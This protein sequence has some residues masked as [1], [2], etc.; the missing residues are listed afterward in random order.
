MQMLNEVAG[1]CLFSNILLDLPHARN[2][3]QSSPGYRPTH[4]ISIERTSLLAQILGTTTI[5]VNS[6][7]RQAVACPGTGLRIVAWADDGVVEALEGTGSQFLLGVQFHPEQ[8]LRSDAIW[9]RLFEG[10]IAACKATNT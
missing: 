10:F 6:F 2:H 5:H 7:H 3:Y 9:V 8:L 1:G 4:P